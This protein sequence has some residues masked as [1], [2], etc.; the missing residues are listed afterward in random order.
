MVKMQ[1]CNRLPPRTALLD[2]FRE[3]DDNTCGAAR[4]PKT[5]PRADRSSADFWWCYLALQRKWT[6]EDTEAKL[7]E[8]SEKARERVHRDPGYVTQTV[9]NAAAAVA[10][11]SQNRGRG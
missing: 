5:V 1:N 8:V 11:N 10:R 7:L 9:L 6:I 3:S 4:R 2:V